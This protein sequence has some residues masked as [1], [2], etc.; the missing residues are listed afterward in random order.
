MLR[1]H[2]FYLSSEQLCAWQ[3][4]RGRLTGGVRFNADRAGVDDFMDYIDSQP[5]APAY[6]VADLI[7]EDFQRVSLPHVTGGAGRALRA[8][9]LLQQY[10]E[11]PFRQARIQGRDSEGRRDDIALFSALT[12]PALLQPWIEALE[13]LKLPLAGLY[14]TTLL[15]DR[16]LARLGI[17]ME[18][19][20]LVTQQTGGLRQSYFQDGQ[21]KFSRLTPA[22][23]RDGAPVSVAGETGK[24]RQF[25]TSTRLLGRGVV[26]HTV[27]VAPAS[28]LDE[29]ALQCQDGPETEYRFIPLEQAAAAAGL[30]AD[31]D[32]AAHTAQHY[33]DPLLL[34]LLGRQAPASQYTLG[35]A[36]RYYLMWR[37]RLTMYGV[38]AA[39]ALGCV[40]LV[41]SNLWRDAGASA[42]AARLT[43]EAVKFDARYRAVMA[44]MPPALTRTANMKAA[45]TVEQ[46]LRRQGPQ[47]LGMMRQLSA[48]LDKVP[49][50]NVTQLDWRVA[51]PA[52]AS[53]S[54][55]GTASGAPSD[56]QAGGA[57]G[58]AEPISAAMLGIPVA[59]PQA[60]HVAG[61]IVIAQG[62][63]RSVVD[64]VNL[65]AQ[66][67]ARL[68]R[69]TV[70]IE[71][72]PL[73]TRSTV[74]LNA[75]AGAA[76]GAA[77]G[78]SKATFSLNLTWQP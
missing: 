3:W 8:R 13:Q 29:L 41:G 46:M 64:S 26:L 23:D 53:G 45:V 7:E 57:T 9:R 69:M 25:L 2:L 14:S 62:D 73:D 30:R 70:E 48:A 61:E 12:N 33:A 68:P 31:S 37:A 50:I 63:Y 34:A 43:D 49:Q 40:G 10:R 24:T 71:Q 38:A 47:P 78:D 56:M 6:L 54:T 19:V 22:L 44:D 11:T 17:R 74:K 1:K 52:I 58:E 39:V 4:H 18:Q 59:P 51:A 42:D 75:R 21:L 36:R 28:Q 55:A 15:S 65:F 5:Y 27:I 16:L 20:L 60:L 72:L 66:E 76:P 35:N 32:A 77:A 67:L